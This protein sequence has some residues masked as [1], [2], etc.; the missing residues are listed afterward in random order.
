[1]STAIHHFNEAF[2]FQLDPGVDYSRP[3]LACIAEVARMRGR[4]DI[5]REVLQLMGR[6]PARAR[7]PEPSAPL[8]F[9]PTRTDGLRP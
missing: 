8:S 6:E 2:G 7:D 4:G 3:S 5:A 1:M 9:N